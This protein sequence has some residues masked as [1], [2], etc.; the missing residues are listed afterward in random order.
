MQFSTQFQFF[1]DLPLLPL[2]QA[3]GNI[4]EGCTLED[5]LDQFTAPEWVASVTCSHC[6][7]I[8]ASHLLQTQL[9]MNNF[10]DEIQ[11]NV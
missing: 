11:E 2:R 1:N 5:C 9:D 6:A 3:D 7:H 8:A 4:I 10:S